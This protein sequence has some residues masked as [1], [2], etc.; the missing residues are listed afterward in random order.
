M[1]V[2]PQF[3]DNLTIKLLH[4][5]PGKA[6]KVQ[7]EHHLDHDGLQGSW[8]VPG[9]VD[10]CPPE[11]SSEVRP[12][13]GH[14]PHDPEQRTEVPHDDTREQLHA[15]ARAPQRAA[16][17]PN[18]LEIGFW[19]IDRREHRLVVLQDV[20]ARPQWHKVEPRRALIATINILKRQK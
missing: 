14:P 2:R 15:M 19:L 10:E 16:D 17:D 1:P 18:T 7:I 8:I 13:D 6:S 11:M 20:P 4:H 5:E 9:R 12:P 3:F